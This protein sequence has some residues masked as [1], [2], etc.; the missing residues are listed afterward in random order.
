MLARF[1]LVL[2]W[3]EREAVGAEAAS[4]LDEEAAW[5]GKARTGAAV[6][7]PPAPALVDAAAALHF[8]AR[9]LRQSDVVPPATTTG[10]AGDEDSP[11]NNRSLSVLSQSKLSLL[12]P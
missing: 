1:W 4:V 8:S 3:R 12:A 7:T 10:A 6:P 5:G 2:P 11:S 9:A